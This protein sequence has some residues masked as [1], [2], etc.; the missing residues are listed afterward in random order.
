MA[1]YDL[2]DKVAARTHELTEM[3]ASL[4]RT[5]AELVQSEQMSS[6]GRMVAGIAH[7]INNPANF[8]QGNLIYTQYYVE[9]L[10]SVL[11][12]ICEEVPLEKFSDAVQEDLEALDLPFLEADFKKL[13]SSMMVGAERIRDIVTS[14]RSFARLDET[15]LKE[16]DVHESIENAL[17]VI[18]H[19]L[20]AKA[21]RTGIDI[22]K[23]YGELPLVVCF[24]AQINQVGFNLLDNAVDAIDNYFSQED[25]QEDSQG[26]SQ[27]DSQRDFGERLMRKPQIQIKTRC[28][29]ARENNTGETRC[30]IYIRDNGGGIL[31][32]VR[33]SIFDPFFTTKDVGQ[34]TGLGLAISHQIIVEAHGGEL[35]CESAPGDGT[36]M[37]VSLPTN[38]GASAA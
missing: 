14:L 5:H 28:E 2:E 20:E 38:A 12:C 34:G 29:S 32:D 18:H 24:P 6:F 16:V 21:E 4:N 10:I 3:L 35:R 8:I 9:S 19:R 11:L 31:E 23:D 36:T 17:L 1:Y 37:I 30:H 15:G 27:G 13:N 26:D 33:Q 22:V 25:S 7:E